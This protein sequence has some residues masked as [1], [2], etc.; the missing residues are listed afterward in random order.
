MF[1]CSALV[2]PTHTI[3][4]AIAHTELTVRAHAA[5]ADGFYR[6]SCERRI[7]CLSVAT[8]AAFDSESIR[9]R[10]H[11][12]ITNV[13]PH[14]QSGSC[15]ARSEDERKCDRADHVSLREMTR[16]NPAM[17]KITM[18]SRANC[19]SELP[20]SAAPPRR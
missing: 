17:L 15:S 5:L 9:K 16:D 14:Y 3:A 12:A 10:R 11:R 1:A 18:P 4:C 13:I 8:N 19:C 7:S 20:R 2:A 6:C